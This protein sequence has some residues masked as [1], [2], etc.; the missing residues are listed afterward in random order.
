VTPARM[1]VDQGYPIALASLAVACPKCGAEPGLM[2]SGMIAFVHWDRV[3]AA[4]AYR[5]AGQLDLFAER[6]A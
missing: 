5:P 1:T 4:G 2:C 6:A 3:V